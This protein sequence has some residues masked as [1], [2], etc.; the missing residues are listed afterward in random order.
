MIETEKYGIYHAANVDYFSWHQFAK[1]IFEVLNMDVI[2]N[3]VSTEEY[4]KLVPGQTERPKNSRL[5]F[6]SLDD[7][8][9]K[10]LPNHMDALK[11]YLKELNIYE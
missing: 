6:K 8:C 9:F 11:R 4:K 1:E 3:P 10:K 2:V 5:S 7:N